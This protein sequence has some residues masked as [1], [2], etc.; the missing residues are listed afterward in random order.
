[1]EQNC[2]THYVQVHNYVLTRLSI[3]VSSVLVRPCMQRGIYNKSFITLDYI[4]Q[5][6]VLG[7]EWVS[8]AAVASEFSGLVVRHNNILSTCI[9]GNC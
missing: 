8:R 6:V 3:N 1:M 9:V 4:N 5:V 2:N 7:N